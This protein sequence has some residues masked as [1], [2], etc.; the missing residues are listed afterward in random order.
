MPTVSPVGV[1]QDSSAEKAA[2][3]VA[4]VAKDATITISGPAME[5][6]RTVVNYKHR[7]TI[8]AGGAVKFDKIREKKTREVLEDLLAKQAEIVDNT[9][10]NKTQKQ[11][12][13]LFRTLVDKG[14]SANE[15]WAIVSGE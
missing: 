14:M 9:L 3:I 13:D 7:D 15:A 5:N 2:T 6:L 4:E 10:R 1:K 11:Q 12:N 8:I